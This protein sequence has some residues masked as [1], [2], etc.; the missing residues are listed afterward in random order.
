M[1]ASTLKRLKG[2]NRKGSFMSRI[3]SGARRSIKAGLAIAL[4]A[5][6]SMGLSATVA[7]Q[8]SATTVT[9]AHSVPGPKAVEKAKLYELVTPHGIFYTANE[10]EKDNAIA[11]YG[12]KPTQTPL[13]YLA[14]SRFRGG[15]PLYRLRLKDKPSYLVTPSPT[16]RDKLVGSGKFLY[17]GILGFAPTKPVTG[18]EVQVFRLSNNGRWR[19]A[20]AE[21]KDSILANEPGWR[22]DGPVFYQFTSPD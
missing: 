4:S 15:K 13:F 6:V 18:N 7:P 16:E 1:D 8:A 17:E 21:H 20:I 12:F 2:M 3:S 19:L 9:K 14:K 11:K 5:A 10:A 22:L